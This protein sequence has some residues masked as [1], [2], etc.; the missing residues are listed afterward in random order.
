[1]F[2]TILSRFRNY[3]NTG[4]SANFQRLNDLLKEAVEL[5]EEYTEG[6]AEKIS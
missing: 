4:T 1:M 5:R 2:S 3:A 6:I